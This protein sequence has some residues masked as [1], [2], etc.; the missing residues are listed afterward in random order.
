MHWKRHAQARSSQWAGIRSFDECRIRTSPTEN[1]ERQEKRL[2][3]KLHPGTVHG[4]NC[5]CALDCGK[6]CKWCLWGTHENHPTCA[7]VPLPKFPTKD[8]SFTRLDSK[9]E[10]WRIL[11]FKVRST[12]CEHRAWAISRRTNPR[13]HA[14]AHRRNR[15]REKRNLAKHGTMAQPFHADSKPCAAGRCCSRWYHD[16]DAHFRSL[17]L[18]DASCVVF[19]IRTQRHPSL[20]PLSL[21]QRILEE[22]TRP[23]KR[24]RST[25]MTE[26]GGMPPRW[27]RRFGW[28]GFRPSAHC[29]RT[30][31]H[32]PR[33]GSRTPVLKHANEGVV[34]KARG[35]DCLRLVE[36]YVEDDPAVPQA[37][38]AAPDNHRVRSPS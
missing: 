21:V 7:E 30:T 5:T 27:I 19:W 10:G 33:E 38:D 26:K 32:E 24:W 25:P 17:A 35:I 12:C 23:T 20:L 18:D 14:T 28:N 31:I 15:S 8:S 2:V 13:H 4:T 3:E 6:D 34:S 16:V 11:Q 22:W 9:I 29:G 37:P 1:S 36:R